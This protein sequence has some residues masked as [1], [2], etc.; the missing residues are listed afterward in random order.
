[1]NRPMVGHGFAGPVIYSPEYN[2]TVY[3]FS[4]LELHKDRR[5]K[6]ALKKHPK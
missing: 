4:H 5:R 1:M 3:G 2:E 6:T